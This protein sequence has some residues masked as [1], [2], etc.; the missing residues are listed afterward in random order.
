MEMIRVKES[1]RENRERERERNNKTK[2]G[3]VIEDCREVQTNVNGRG[4]G[5][6]VMRITLHSNPRVTASDPL[7]LV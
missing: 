2:W 3:K 1:Q 7:V 4:Q 5:W 6:G